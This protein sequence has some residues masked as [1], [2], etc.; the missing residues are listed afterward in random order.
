[1]I[2]ISTVQLSVIPGNIRANFEQMERE[3]QNARKQNTDILIFPEL[4]LSGYMIGDLWEQ[5]AF[6]RE[7]ERYGQKIADAAEN[8]IVIFGNIAVDPKKKNNACVESFLPDG[9]CK[10]R[11]QGRYGLIFFGSQLRKACKVAF[12]I[13]LPVIREQRFNS[14]R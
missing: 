11:K 13:K 14:I 5:N 4:C 3:I 2:R 12:V 1:M 7:C 9:K 8:I 6:L 10:R